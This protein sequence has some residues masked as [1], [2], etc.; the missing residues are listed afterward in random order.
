MSAKVDCAINLSLVDTKKGNVS[1]KVICGDGS[2]KTLHSTYDPE[3]EAKELVD[4]FQ[5]DGKGILIVLGL[6][7]GYHLAELAQ[8][9]PE[10]E[11]IVVEE[12]PE[13]YD[14]SLKHGAGIESK[15]NYLIG[16][17]PDQALKEITKRQMTG[18]ISP[19]AVFQLSSAISAFNSYY[20]PILESLK[21]TVSIKLWERF[22]YQKFREENQK[23]I[24][25][26]SGYF[27]VREVEKALFARGNKVVR[28]SVN[29]KDRG[30]AVIPKIMETILEF[31]PDFVLTMNHLGFDEDGVL[32]SFFKSIEMPVA[33]WYVD[34]P[35]LIVR[36]FDK[37]VSPYMSLFLWD[38]SYIR[39]M[40][41]MGF[42]SVL[43]LPLGTDE[44]V[45]RP[46]SVRKH[47]KK[48][49][50]YFCDAGFVG[51]SMVEP[52]DE[53]MSKVRQDNHPL[54][55][56]LAEK[57]AGSQRS[58][59]NILES[60]A[61]DDKKVIEGFSEKEKMDFEAAVLWKATLLYR[62]SCVK[63]LEG[64]DV[65]IYGD[66]GW[67]NLINGK[68][69]KLFS[70]LNYYKDLP[71][72]YNA[73]RV[74]FNATSRQMSEAVNQRV[75]DVSACD[76]FLLTDYQE[77]L[78]ELF[79]VGKE[80]IAYRDK[81]EIPELVRYYLKNADQRMAVAQKARKRVM[82]EHTYRHRLTSLIKFMKDKYK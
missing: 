15:V 53:W 63:M 51:N 52:V 69:I 68:S 65:R 46:V 54:V 17:S 16:L 71:L 72:F 22:K 13:I 35:N 61:N 56:R 45:F 10:A 82:K 81:G 70:P 33:S 23:V 34:S 76:A 30:E 64:D 6:G 55:E 26:D 4:A 24:L 80:I 7:L 78:E 57:L 12:S 29:H 43:H 77:S 59:L 1:L 49:N 9:F 73:C 38:K 5:F 36:A 14:L 19:L 75:F 66:R 20:Q 62:L 27:L 39:D 41:S 60:L 47:R 44:S 48:L 32:T 3:D 31:K 50:K 58:F 21:K 67:V 79:E 25:V 37:N 8:R 40:K 74:N 11:I 42:E 28:I 18:G 2:V